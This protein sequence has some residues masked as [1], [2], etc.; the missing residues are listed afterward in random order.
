MK[1][2]S[3]SLTNILA[4][5]F[6]IAFVATTVLAFAFYNVERSAFDTDLYI[7]SFEAENVYERLPELTAQ[8]LASAAQRPGRNDMLAL[9]R[10]LSEEEWRTFVTELFPPDVLRILAED[11]ITQIMAYLNG[12]NESVVLSL[13]SLRAH[14][15]SQ[16]GINAIYG[17]LKAQPDCTLEQLTAMTLN[18]Q[19]LTLCNPPDTFLIFDLRP[20]IEAEIKVAMSLIPEQITLISADES[21]MQTLRD[22][23]ALRLFMR[24]SPILPIF[25]LLIVTA[26]VVRSLK[27]W[28]NWWGYPLLFVGLISMSLSA[29]SGFLAAGTFQFFIAPALPDAL[30]SAIVEVFRDLTGA[31]VYNALRP[32]LLVA[33]IM[34]LTGLI[35][36]ALTFLLRQRFQKR[37]ADMS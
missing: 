1:D 27:D 11:V 22:L 5:L 25:C 28:L 10:N 9:F 3:T 36:V 20:I 24:L 23:K 12:E 8:A 18:Q 32:T 2:S 15:Q 37:S 34:A 13:T 30:P 29:M 35:M 21:Q 16:E 14:L 6:A 33:G 7:R 26:L 17:M 31:I 19:A 4:I